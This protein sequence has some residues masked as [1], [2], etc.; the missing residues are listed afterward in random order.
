MINSKIKE[1]IEKYSE[2]LTAIRRKLHSEPE[3]SWEEYETTAF[4]SA[5]LTEL[6]IE[7]RKTEPTGVIAEIKGGKPGETVALRADMD[8]LPVEELN[9]RSSLCVKR[10]RENACMWPRYTY[11]NASN[12]SKSTQ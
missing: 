7:H 5:Y 12:C 8:A 4:V 3:L 2:E 9:T 1:G 11:G 6:G 10:K